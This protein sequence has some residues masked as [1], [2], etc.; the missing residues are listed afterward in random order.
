MLLRNYGRGFDETPFVSKGVYE[1][2]G[3]RFEF[4]GVYVVE[5]A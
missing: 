4:L 2:G 1:F 3:K 5:T